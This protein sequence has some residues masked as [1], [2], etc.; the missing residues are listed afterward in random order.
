MNSDDTD[1]S[2]DIQPRIRLKGDMIGIHVPILNKTKLIDGPN[3]FELGIKLTKLGRR[4]EAVYTAA[5]HDADLAHE[6]SPS[7]E[8]SDQEK[9]EYKVFVQ[10]AMMHRLGISAEEDLD[11][12]DVPDEWGGLD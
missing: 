2:A 10:E 4:L 7:G 12:E 3:A 9:L 1:F 8:W 5:K 6:G 11:L